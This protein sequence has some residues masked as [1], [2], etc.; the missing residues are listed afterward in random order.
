MSA[1]QRIADG[2]FFFRMAAAPNSGRSR[3]RGERLLWQHST[4][5]RRLGEAMIGAFHRRPYFA[6]TYST[7]ASEPGDV[8]SS[9]WKMSR[10]P[11][12]RSLSFLNP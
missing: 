6:R 2:E 11:L 10:F 4:E 7:L 9:N 5:N 12:T 3:C 8:L 1:Y